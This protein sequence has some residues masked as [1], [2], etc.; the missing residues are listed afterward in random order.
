MKMQTAV[1]VL[2]DKRGTRIDSC[3]LSQIFLFRLW[4]SINIKRTPPGDEGPF[5][6]YPRLPNQR[7]TEK[8]V[9]SWVTRGGDKSGVISALILV[10]QI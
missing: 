8:V 7:S 1:P 6:C 5:L 4:Y 3:R 9:D 2:M 10:S